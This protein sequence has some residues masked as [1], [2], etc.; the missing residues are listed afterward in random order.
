MAGTSGYL[1]RH[2][3]S[4][5]PLRRRSGGTL[6]AARND[7]LV[8]KMRSLLILALLAGAV[9][10]AL[11][12][13]HILVVDSPRRADVAVV[14]GGDFNDQRYWR[15]LQLLR[16]GWVQEMILD[17]DDTA[18]EFGQKPSHYA[19][20]FV[21][22]TAGDFRTHIHLCPIG[23]D[24]TVGETRF[25]GGCLRQVRARTGLLVTSDYHTRRAL[26]IFRSR[27]PEYDW[28]VAAAY[29][30]TVF[31]P[32]WWKKRERAK[33]TLIEWER[34]AWWELVDRWRE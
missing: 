3:R 28:S 27:L 21:E 10:F 22:K 23:E 24:S 7:T 6:R 29:D 11:R 14:L 17:V 9:L 26:S 19:Q 12:C 25:V 1:R 15:G 30:E 16:G 5:I 2:V 18:L 13:G 34:M 31:A 8:G 32:E 33:T 4:R 20:A